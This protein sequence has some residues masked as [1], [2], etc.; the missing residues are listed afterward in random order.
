MK[1]F[2]MRDVPLHLLGFPFKL[3]RWKIMGY[4][5]R[6]E[7]SSDRICIEIFLTFSFNFFF[8]LRKKQEMIEAKQT[9]WLAGNFFQSGISSDRKNSI[10]FCIFIHPHIITCS[11]SCYTFHRIFSSLPH[12][13]CVFG[14]KRRF[15]NMGDDHK[16]QWITF[17]WIIKMNNPRM[18]KTSWSWQND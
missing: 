14:N 16:V 11:I 6:V 5:E 9:L 10:D 18:E 1:Y 7:K 17:Q 4:R 8:K 2:S 13:S 12:D 15:E 3:S